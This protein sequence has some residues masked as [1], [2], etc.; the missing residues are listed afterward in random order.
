[1]QRRANEYNVIF[2]DVSITHL[3]FSPDFARSIEQK[4]VAQQAAERAKY[5][6]MM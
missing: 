4:Q 5:V 2:D 6:V 1:L 3:Q